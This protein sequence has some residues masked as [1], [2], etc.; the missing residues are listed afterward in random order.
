[1]PKSPIFIPGISPPP[2]GLL[3]RFLPPIPVGVA[4]Q[5]LKENIQTGSW[6]LDPFGSNPWMIAEIARAG[7][8]ILVAANNP[9][10]RFLV[11]LTAN[12]LTRNDIRLALAELA[13][14]RSGEERLES[15]LNNL[16]LTICP[17]CGRPLPARAFL[18][19]KDSRQPYARVVQCE[20]CGES[21]EYDLTEE[22]IHLLSRFQQPGLHRARTLERIAPFGDPDRIHAEEALNAYLPRTIYALALVINRLEGLTSLS[23]PRHNNS[24]RLMSLWAIALNAFDQGNV[25]WSHLSSR[26]RPRLLS[27]SPK[28]IEYNIWHALESTA[29]QF[30]VEVFPLQVFR[31][32]EIPDHE[33]GIVLFE[34]PLRELY[35]FYQQLPGGKIRIAA[36]IAAIPRPNQAFWTLSALWAGW[37]WGREAVGPFR[38]VLRRRRYDWNWHC[39]ALTAG[40]SVLSQMV[41]RDTPIL[42][43]VAEA[44]PNFITATLVASYLANLSLEGVA[45]RSDKMFAQVHW[46][47][48][49]P[50]SILSLPVDEKFG[51]SKAENSII[52]WAKNHLRERGEPADY[53]V[54]HTGGLTCLVSSDQRSLNLQRDAGNAYSRIDQ[55]IKDCFTYK[56]GFLRYGGGEKSPE[57]GLFWHNEIS[58]PAVSLMDRIETDFLNIMITEKEAS[59]SYLDNS[60][61]EKFPGFFTPPSD[62]IEALI[63]SYCDESSINEDILKLRSEDLPDARRADLVEIQEIL[64]LLSQRLGFQV[65]GKQPTKWQDL[66]ENIIRAFYLVPDAKISQIIQKSTFPPQV[67]VIVLP[68]ARA[69]LVLYKLQHDPL[70]RMKVAA[71]WRFIKFRHLRSLVL[72]PLISPENIQEL[73]DSDPITEAPAQLRLL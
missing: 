16:Y 52:A 42:G 44:E 9:I 66:N 6:I 22:D 15:Y 38:T 39:T 37:L 70:L 72:S 7:F 10:N 73:L 17:G 19:E 50:P 46:R 1:M 71:G 28:F 21:G 64:I 3:S 67:T 45:L 61:C 12:S 56:K 55:L 2:V 24:L 35:S 31:W 51:Q 68:G 4:S 41:D 29:T 5:W 65:T 8:N 43:M 27:A 32:P 13:A 30:P 40:F 54:I 18:W 49:A 48:G 23:S 69:N 63:R 59:R 34:G 11:E 33:G 57:T 47:A 20:V 25:L 60:L 26:P 62:L 36:V 53:H 14:A 58:N